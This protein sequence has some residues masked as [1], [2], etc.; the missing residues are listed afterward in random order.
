MD[1]VS[2]NQV[3]LTVPESLILVLGA[4]T[5]NFL[6]IESPNK[7]SVNFQSQKFRNKYADILNS[8]LLSGG[9]TVCA[10]RYLKNETAYEK[11]A[12]EG[13]LQIVEH[14][15]SESF[16]TQLSYH[17]E[18]AFLAYR[19]LETHPN[20]SSKKYLRDIQ[21]SD[22]WRPFSNVDLAEKIGDL[23]F[24]QKCLEKAV[25]SIT[26]S[27]Q[28]LFGY[29]FSEIR[30]FYD[31]LIE[32]AISDRVPEGKVFDVQNL[33]AEGSST[34]SLFEIMGLEIRNA[35]LQDM[36]MPLFSFGWSSS[37]G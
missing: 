28:G 32:E 23:E 27:L 7:N 33:V 5:D 2:N 8:I 17:Y 11:L 24:H 31:S 36:N 29:H 9:A 1:E 3:L 30:S 25:V 37:P 10:P 35:E 26:E 16:R 4:E 20:Y 13:L 22:G 6:S 18:K 15:Y 14:N 21:S 19:E 12:A 34:N